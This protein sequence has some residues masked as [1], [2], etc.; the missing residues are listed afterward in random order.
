[1]KVSCYVHG[2]NHDRC[3]TFSMPPANAVE[4]YCAEQGLDDDQEIIVEP[5]DDV[6]RAL[7]GWH[8]DGDGPVFKMFRVTPVTR[9]EAREVPTFREV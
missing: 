8:D 6:A 9:W 4:R 3:Y 2:A 5:M 1:M 7:H